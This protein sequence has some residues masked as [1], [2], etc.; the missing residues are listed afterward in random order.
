VSG[1][2]WKRGATR[3]RFPQEGNARP[4]PG[5]ASGARQTAGIRAALPCVPWHSSAGLRPPR[6]PEAPAGLRGGG[7]GGA[8]VGGPAPPASLGTSP[9]PPPGSAPTRKT[10][11]G[12]GIHGYRAPGPALPA[13][14][15]PRSFTGTVRAA[16]P[17]ARDM[18]PWS[19]GAHGRGG[20]PQPGTT[21]SG[22]RGLR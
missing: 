20:E 1:E 5:A 11:P 17:C 14:R 2:D 7:G 18:W 9:A 16:A 21:E 19:W 3:P 10:P 12:P 4:V 22:C 15:H 6:P 13:P 8:E